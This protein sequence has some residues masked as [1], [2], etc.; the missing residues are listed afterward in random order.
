MELRRIG[1][2]PLEN[3]I[4]IYYAAALIKCNI[5]TEKIGLK[6]GIIFGSDNPGLKSGANGENVRH[7]WPLSRPVGSHEYISLNIRVSPGVSPLVFRKNLVLRTFR[8]LTFELPRTSVIFY[9]EGRQSFG[10]SDLIPSSCPGLQ[11][12]SIQ[13]DFSPSD[14]QTSYIPVAPDFSPGLKDPEIIFGLQPNIF[15]ADMRGSLLPL[16]D[17]FKSSQS[18]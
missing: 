1:V 18:L 4:L 16:G 10:H 9:S 11:S 14:I 5:F 2:Q 7:N 3:I 17:G 6:S 15:N 13:K 8:P 12:S